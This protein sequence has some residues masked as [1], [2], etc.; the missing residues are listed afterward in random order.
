LRLIPSLL[1]LKQ[2]LATQTAREK[3]DVC[4]TYITR[5]GGWYQVSWKGS[6]EK[7]GGVAMNIGIHFFHLVTWLFGEPERNVLH[8]RTA[9]K[10]AGLLEL[11]KARVHWFLSTDAN[12]LPEASKR[13]NQF[14]YRSITFDGQEIEFSSGFKDLHTR[15][16]QEVLAGRGPG[17]RDARTG[18]QLVY[19]LNQSE[20]VTARGDAHP[21]LVGQ[22]MSTL[23]FTRKAA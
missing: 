7:S 1:A 9:E 21:A 4:L 17:I 2:H 11:E 14:A 6:E 19:D 12:D 5:R 8:L 15:V 18:I 22:R 16:Y 3:A 13:N 23:A 20:V 10:M